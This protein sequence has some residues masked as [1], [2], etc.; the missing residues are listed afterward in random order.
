MSITGKS[1]TNKSFVN[2]TSV[3]KHCGGDI[4]LSQN[5]ANVS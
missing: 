4:F 1:T 3:I 5:E 2:V